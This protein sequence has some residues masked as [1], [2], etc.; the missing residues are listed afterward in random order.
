MSLNS[1]NPGRVLARSGY[2]LRC[3]R[4]R[5][6]IGLGTHFHPKFRADRL[7]LEVEPA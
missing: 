7:V 2:G 4:G 5:R 3:G 6:F 1:E